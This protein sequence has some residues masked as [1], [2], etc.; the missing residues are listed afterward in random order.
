MPAA[1]THFPP[2]TLKFLAQLKRNNN[3]DWFNEHKATYETAIKAPSLAFADAMNAGLARVAPAYITEPKQAV[4]R[5]YRDTRFSADKTPYKTHTAFLFRRSNMGKH[6][7]GSFYVG[8]S[9]DGVELG[10]GVYMPGPEQLMAIRLHLAGHHK[11]FEK[12]LA[13]AKLRQLAGELK[14]TALTRPPKG[15]DTGHPAGEWIRR[16]QWFFFQTLPATLATSP[17]LIPVLSKAIGAMIPA[18]EFL[19]EPLAGL[20]KQER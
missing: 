8:I 4:Y 6:D 16:K 11:R 13:N 14:G 18:V 17:E 7:S 9:P 12:L 5:I 20:V 10:G 1:F 2:A 15:F 19:N 3:R